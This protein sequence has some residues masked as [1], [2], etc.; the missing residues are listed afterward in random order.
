MKLMAGNSNLPLARAIAGYL[1]IPLTDASVRRFADEEVFV[2]IH[3]NVRGEDVFVLQSTSFPAN[4]NLM[5]LLIC[6]DALKRAISAM[7][8]RIANP[9]RARPSVPSWSPT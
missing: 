5:E 9:A 6:I 3:E 7:P 4:D 1:E 2:E 8:G